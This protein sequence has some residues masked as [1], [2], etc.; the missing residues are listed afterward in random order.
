MTAKE[1]TQNQEH[2][3]QGG[4]QEQRCR[5]KQGTYAIEGTPA[6]TETISIAGASNCGDASS[7]LTAKRQV[8][9]RM[10]TVAISGTYLRTSNL[11]SLSGILTRSFIIA[12]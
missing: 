9:T 7:V 10:A 2:L 11:Y 3:S 4:Q 5:Q 8:T 1:G 12:I 6:T